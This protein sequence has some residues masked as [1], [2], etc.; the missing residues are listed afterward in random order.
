MHDSLG[1]ITQIN[2]RYS[3]NSYCSSWTN[4]F[5]LLT[6]HSQI[7]ST[8]IV[9][10]H[11]NQGLIYVTPNEL[12]YAN[13]IF[14]FPFRVQHVKHLDQKLLYE[15]ASSFGG[16]LLLSVKVNRRLIITDH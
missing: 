3:M 11:L 15:E 4:G 6:S 13:I 5:I 14:F 12:V 9:I 16:K 2:G 7:I 8:L 10:C 1:F